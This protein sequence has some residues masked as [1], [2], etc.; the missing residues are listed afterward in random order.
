V[1]QLRVGI[2]GLGAMGGAIAERLATSGMAPL[3]YDIDARAVKRLAAMG[4]VPTD[5]GGVFDCDILMTSLPSD[6]VLKDVLADRSVLAKLSGGILVELSTVTPATVLD[7]AS[8]AREAGFDVIDC[9]V[10]G[11]PG[12]ARA[13]SLVLLVGADDAVVDRALPVLD[14]LGS[15]ERVGG[16]GAGKAMKLV[17][18]TMSMGNMAVAAEAFALGMSL[19]LEPKKM[20]ETL[21]RSGGRSLAF[22]KRMPYAL[23]D[24]YSPRFALR[25]GEKDLRLALEVG[26]ASTYPMPVAACVHQIYEFAMASGLADEDMVAILKFFTSRA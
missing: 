22:T 12:E 15:I 20:Y 14:I 7:V 24:D 9:P 2:I 5:R 18:N 4:A 26:H 19:G 21:S 11:G 10:S 25:L 17:N 13:G 3:I 16:V 8:R 6:A 1:T 23:D